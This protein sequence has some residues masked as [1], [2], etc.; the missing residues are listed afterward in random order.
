MSLWCRNIRALLVAANQYPR[1]FEFMTKCAGMKFHMCSRF[2]KAFLVLLVTHAIFDAG[3]VRAEG[4]IVTPALS[5]DERFDGNFRL[6]TEP[7]DSVWTSTLSGRVELARKTDTTELR[8]FGL[9]SGLFYSGETRG[10]PNQSNQLAGVSGLKRTELDAWGLNSTYTRDSVIRTVDLIVEPGGVESDVAQDID[11]DLTETPVRRARFRVSPSWRRT[12][13][14]RS[15]FQ[16]LYRF[17]D[18]S[19]EE[20]EGQSLTDFRDHDING[21]LSYNLTDVDTLL[22]IADVGLFRPDNITEWNSYSLQLGA[23]RD[24]SRTMSAGFTAGG[25]Y[26]TIKASVGG[27]QAESDDTGFVGKVY[28]NMR[29]ESARFRAALER[30][31]L[32]SGSGDMLQTDQLLIDMT[33]GISDQ[34]AFLMRFRAF[35][36]KSLVLT[37]SS[38]DRTYLE[39]IPSLQW[40]L[41]PS[42]TVEASYR[43]ARDDREDDPEAAIGNSVAVSLTYE[44]PRI[45]QF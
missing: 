40:N 2:G 4:W 31:L 29:T 18:V 38:S 22:A 11:V 16:F 25:R 35:K 45:L 24:F 36:T 20:V 12:L 10:L 39:V 32:P 42:W 27:L 7:K 28:G 30:Q 37:D 26:T 8:A 6:D 41:D 14:E 23:E 9:I 44:Q 1:V 17:Q 13:T 34:F 15:D 33:Q 3:T 19:F 5:V 43:F 21:Q